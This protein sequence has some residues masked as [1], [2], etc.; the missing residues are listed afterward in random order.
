MDLVITALLINQVPITL[1]FGKQHCFIRHANSSITY[2][3][4]KDEEL[5]GLL[6]QLFRKLGSRLAGVD[7]IPA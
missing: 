4:I 1:N 5:L 3:F 7:H 6:A 2:L